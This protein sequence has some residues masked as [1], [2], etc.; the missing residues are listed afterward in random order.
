MVLQGTGAPAPYVL[1]EVVREPSDDGRFR[2]MSLAA[3]LAG[4]LASILTEQEL[5]AMDGGTTALARWR[6]GDDNTFALDTM[7]EELISEGW[8]RPGA[9][10]L[11]AMTLDEVSLLVERNRKRSVRVRANSEN[12]R[13]RS[14]EL[15]LQVNSRKRRDHDRRVNGMVS[16]ATTATEG[17]EEQP[18]KRRRHLRPV[19]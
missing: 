13:R 2:E 5:R 4:P 9:G 3:N 19:S 15:R 17:L 18:T 8:W 1:A 16:G 6:K 7:A 11:K 10:S 14:A 12:V